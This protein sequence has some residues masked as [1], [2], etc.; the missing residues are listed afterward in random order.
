[1][2]QSNNA[3]AEVEQIMLRIRAELGHHAPHPPGLRELSAPSPIFKKIDEHLSS[4]V[5]LQ[6]ADNIPVPKRIQLELGE[7]RGG[8]EQSNFEP[9]IGRRYHIRELFEYQDRE[10]INAAYWTLLEREPDDG[11]LNTYL[12]LLRAG[13]SKIEILE[14]LRDSPEGRLAK[15]TVAGLSTQSR[16]LKISRWPVLGPLGRIANALWNLPAEQRRQR[17][18]QGDLFSL[19]EKNRGRATEAL[20]IVNRALRDVETAHHDLT[21]YAASKLGN[22]ANR[23]IEASI[24]SINDSVNELRNLANGKANSEDVRRALGEVSASREQLLR[25]LETKIERLELTALA[26]T[27]DVVRGDVRELKAVGSGFA[28]QMTVMRAEARHFEAH[29]QK[30][31]LEMAGL[32]EAQ[33]LL[34]SALETKAVGSELMT[35]ESTMRN[36][37]DEVCAELRKLTADGSG[38]AQRIAVMRSEGMYFSAHIEKSNADLARLDEARQS[39]IRLLEAKAERAELK[40]LEFTIQN[41]VD[42]VGGDL[43]NFKAE[44]GLRATRIDVLESE[45]IHFS[46]H[47]EKSSSDIARLDESCQLM[48]RSLETK[49]ERSELTALTDHILNVVQAC[50][51]TENIATIKTSLKGALDAAVHMISQLSE[52]KVDRATIETYKEETQKLLEAMRIQSEGDLQTALVGVNARTRDI[53]LN[54]IDQERRL[55]L[56]LEEAR[57]RLPKPISADQ[58]EKMLTEEDHVLDAMYAEFEDIFRGT[59]TDISQ[60]QS[61]YIPFVREAGAGEISS[62]IVDIGCGRGEWLELLR[63]SG[64]RAQGVDTNRIFLQRCRDLSLDV[65]ESDAITFLRGAKHNSLGGVT[66]FHLIEH[67]PHKVLIAMLD[68]AFR[69]LRPG[70]VII[71]ETP[72]PRNLQVASCNFYLDPT[73]RHPLPPD[74]MKF[75]MEARGFVSIEIKELHPFSAENHATGGPPEINQILNR[76]LFSSQDYAIIGRKA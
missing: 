16:L 45:R 75:V 70:G 59:R 22:D 44:A 41:S 30:S 11:G 2:A 48:T 46:A 10:F 43:R 17:V 65:I 29:I 47:V 19:I 5:R 58:I 37:I 39:L 74:L 6:P 71:L 13:T 49:A 54:L 40:S 25:S 15:T 4:A 73:H 9:K 60:R 42:E 28:D 55:V 36:S 32:Q 64:L 67:L 27:V 53:K 61:I 62:P 51:T 72:N 34:T 1:V 69:A 12:R 68:A 31:K 26:S 63:D 76:F 56:L 14:F 50:P 33:R 52:T 20:R 24:V 23:R 8:V 38:F 7:D 35:L 18:V 57:R 21:A 66:S 3:E